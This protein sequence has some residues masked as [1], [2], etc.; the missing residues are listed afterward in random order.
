VS[1]VKQYRHNM[2][3]GARDLFSRSQGSMDPLGNGNVFISWGG[4][5]AHLTEFTR[6][7]D[8]TFESRLDPKQVDTYRAYRMPWH[9]ATG[10]NK[11]DA[12]AYSDGSGTD[13]YVSWNGA[14]NVAQ[15]VVQAGSDPAEMSKV[16]ESGWENFETRIHIE[17]SPK[18]VRVKALSE[19]G[20]VLGD[21]VTI[22]PKDV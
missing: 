22:T 1:L 18:Y 2:V 13:V 14:T 9:N 16:G 15:W 19:G 12:K 5:N 21:T 17:G 20:T 10:E 8:V 4:G 6:D 3:P 11:P 7:G